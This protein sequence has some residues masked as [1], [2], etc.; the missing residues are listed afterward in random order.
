MQHTQSPPIYI[1]DSF[2]GYPVSSFCLQHVPADDLSSVLIPGGLVKDRIERLGFDI[3]S[4]LAKEDFI[5]L[6]VLKGGFQFFNQLIE[7]V[8]QHHRF[9][10]DQSMQGIKAGKAQRIQAEFI[11]LISYE[12]DSSKGKVQIIGME[13]LASLR[14]QNVLVVEDIIDSGLTITTLLAALDNEKPKTVKVASLFYKRT[15]KNRINYHP[16]CK[17]LT[18]LA[19]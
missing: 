12:N 11:R 19:W 6:C 15:K 14:G 18:C 5:F 2:E 4:D 16:D 10:A 7:V 17:Y 1:P 9:N 8:R 3:S 13:N